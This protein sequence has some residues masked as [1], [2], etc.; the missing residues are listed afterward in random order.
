MSVHDKTLSPAGGQ[1]GKA[2]NVW[3]LRSLHA[4]AC[5]ASAPNRRLYQVSA[6]VSSSRAFH[7]NLLKNPKRGSQLDHLLLG[8][9][10]MQGWVEHTLFIN[11]GGGGGANVK[12]VCSG[13]NLGMRS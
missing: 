8:H 5:L 12:T 6:C 7:L 9:I 4:S 1:E 11:G 13:A 2:P 10:C 3:P